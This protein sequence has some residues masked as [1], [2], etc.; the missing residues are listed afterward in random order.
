MHCTVPRSSSGEAKMGK[1]W[2][3]QGLSSRPNLIL[4]CNWSSEREQSCVQCPQ[5]QPCESHPSP[6][7]MVRKEWIY[8]LAEWSTPWTLTF[9][10][11][12]VLLHLMRTN[13][14]NF[15]P[16]SNQIL[17]YLYR[18][19][20]LGQSKHISILICGRAGILGKILV[21]LSN[22]KFDSRI[23]HLGV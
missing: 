10:F 12:L 5:P 1:G 9:P 15:F 11:S 19:V 7:G 4:L 14:S 8:G 18:S 22:L 2:I 23:T 13:F 6:A 16:W 20:F 21:D 3:N 17:S